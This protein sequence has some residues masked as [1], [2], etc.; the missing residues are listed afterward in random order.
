[1]DPVAK[2]RR[3]TAAETLVLISILVLLFMAFTGHPGRLGEEVHRQLRTT[4][5]YVIS[6]P[7]LVLTS[8]ILLL[9]R[10]VPANPDQKSF[11]PSSLMDGLFTFVL[12]PTTSALA[13]TLTAPVASW[14]DAHASYLVVHATD[15]LP[16][17]VAVAL[18]VLIGDFWAWFIHMVNHK[19]PIFWRFHVVHHSQENLTFFTSNK[20]HPLDLLMDL[21]VLF[22]PFYFRLS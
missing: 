9:E 16:V 11:T 20:V 19:V 21:A 10:L 12:I 14:L 15:T 8:G 2:R 4:L 13:I 17:G 5:F 22:L 7:F 3:F 18:G 1:M 6:L